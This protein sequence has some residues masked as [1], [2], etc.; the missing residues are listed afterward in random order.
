MAGNIKQV[1]SAVDS[2]TPSDQGVRSAVQAAYRGG[3]FFDQM[4]NAKK[5]TE[6]TLG[7][8]IASTVKDVGD[9]ALTYA[10]HKDVSQYNLAAS[11]IVSDATTA[12]NQKV[13][14]VK[15]PDGSWAQEP[16][17][18]DDPAA[19]VAFMEGLQKNLD[20]I[21]DSMWT[22]RGQEVAESHNTEIRNHF[23]ASTTAQL[24]QV[25]AAHAQEKAQ[26]TPVS[27][28]HLTL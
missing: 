9:V 24:S 26:V 3:R 16:I 13:S 7:R 19:K 20:S 10:Q 22:D 6:E 4:A 5:E 12:W 21:K 23:D 27:Y 28:T 25:A 18:P 17:N 8:N 15:N 2:L 14:G 1:E 11:K